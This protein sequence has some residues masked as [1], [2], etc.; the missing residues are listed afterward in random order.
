M[1]ER[2]RTTAR[3]YRTAMMEE[4]FALRKALFEC[5]QLLD[6]ETLRQRLGISE[7]ALRG[8]LRRRSLFY[9]DGPSGAR[10]YPAFLAD[11]AYSSTALAAVS[12]ALGTLPGS[13][14]WVFFTNPRGSLGGLSPLEIL[15]GKRPP[16][17]T[18][19][20]VGLETI[21]RAARAEVEF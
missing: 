3:D 10:Y 12:R 5:G 11:P 6:R 14:K 20:G 17:G 4:A 18:A 15:A 9:V 7:L 2:K 13:T 8:W 16:G 1:T 19:S 21:L